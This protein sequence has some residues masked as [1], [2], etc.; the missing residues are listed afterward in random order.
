M[1]GPH[2]MGG[3]QCYGPVDIEADEPLFHE[4][5]ERRALALTVAMGFTGMWN[6]DSSRHARESL[7]PVQYLSSSYYQIWL[8]A[9][10]NLLLDRDML[11]ASELARGAV[12]TPA[13]AT[14]RPVPDRE[15]VKVG[16]AAGAPTLRDSQSE[17]LFAVGATVQ[18][19]NLNPLTHT[20]LPS[21]ARGKR[22]RILH[23]N[24]AHVFPDTNAHAQ[25]ENPCQLYTVE[26]AASELFGAGRHRVT[27]DLWEP[28]LAP[29]A[30]GNA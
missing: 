11:S 5:W 8:A 23:L 26:F 6:I 3:M 28:Y 25:G 29:H 12:Q 17:P 27:L 1:N 18:T 24:G 15:A 21:Y 20:R 16:L 14:R 19:R 13:V 2:D 9:L 10:E 22:G 7:P 30:E 4:H